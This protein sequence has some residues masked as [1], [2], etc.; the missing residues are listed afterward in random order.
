MPTLKALQ[1]RLPRA[2]EACPPGLRSDLRALWRATLP[3]LQSAKRHAFGELLLNLATDT[4]ALLQDAPCGDGVL[5]LWLG[6]PPHHGTVEPID[7]VAAKL[8][9]D[10][11]DA[12]LK[13]A[14]VD[15]D[16]ALN[17]TVTM[18]FADYRHRSRSLPAAFDA[19]C[20]DAD[21]HVTRCVLEHF[22]AELRSDLE[23]ATSRNDLGSFEAAL[24][25]ASL[26]L[27]AQAWE[28]QSGPL[29]ALSCLVTESIH[30]LNMSVANTMTAHLEKL[31]SHLATLR[32]GV[33]ASTSVS[34]GLSSRAASTCLAALQRA[35]DEHDID[36]YR[37]ALKKL[38]RHPRRVVAFSRDVRFRVV[39]KYLKPRLHPQ[40]LRDA[41]ALADRASTCDRADVA[42]VLRQSLDKTCAGVQSVRDQEDTAQRHA[43]RSLWSEIWPELLDTVHREDARGY[44]RLLDR[45]ITGMAATMR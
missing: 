14:R 21:P 15:L 2:V 10:Q 22:S 36:A 26:Q 11:I 25:F 1:A 45:L 3:Q 28:S 44:A 29:Q 4:R 9:K 43:L 7:T 40:A 19:L 12:S 20:D 16:I 17:E 31:R 24:M 33:P 8:K 18:L 37:S 34:S 27:K 41:M 32:E 6:E 42:R 30:A 38:R 35:I 5:A 23:E 13:K 39:E